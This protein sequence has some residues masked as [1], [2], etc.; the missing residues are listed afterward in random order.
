MLTEIAIMNYTLDSREVAE[1]VGKEHK[2]LFADIRGYVENMENSTELKVQPSDFFKKS[3]YIDPTGRTLPCYLVTRKGCDMIANKMIGQKGTLFTALYITRFYDMEQA[4]Q[5]SVPAIQKPHAPRTKPVDMIFRQRL[6][7]VRDFA[8]ITGIPLGIAVATAIDDAERMTGEDYAYWKLSLLART[9][10]KP[11][12]HLN[13]TQLGAL[14]GLSAHDTNIRL[15][16]A[17][18]QSKVDKC[19]RLTEA[20]KLHGEEY[21]FVRNGHSDYSI[22]W[23]ES[24]MSAIKELLTSGT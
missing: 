3:S 17:G 22:R 18:L 24:A 9:D 6:N 10:E 4:L 5:T 16:A 12:P 15:E 21:P 23:R 20:G 2:N 1:M 14:I 19:W 11:V 7:M 13:A 8:R